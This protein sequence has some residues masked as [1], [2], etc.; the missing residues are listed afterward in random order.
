MRDVIVCCT[1]VLAAFS[2]AKPSISRTCVLIVNTGKSPMLQTRLVVPADPREDRDP[3]PQSARPIPFFMSAKYFVNYVKSFLVIRSLVVIDLE[4]REP[5]SFA[6]RTSSTSA[7]TRLL[8]SDSCFPL[9]QTLSND[10]VGRQW[11]YGAVDEWIHRVYRAHTACDTSTQCPG[12]AHTSSPFYPR[13]HTHSIRH[14][15]RRGCLDRDST[16]GKLRLCHA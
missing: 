7:R 16:D 2:L 1:A 4:D 9:G 11:P 14:H 10:L 6:G 5:R 15:C 12:G 3:S 8:Y 13:H